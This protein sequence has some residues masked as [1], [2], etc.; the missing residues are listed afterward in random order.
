MNPEKFREKLLADGYLDIE[1]KS[2]EA[3][4]FVDKHSHAFDVRALVLEGEAT[5]D[6][7]GVPRT[8]RTGDVLEVAR[9]REHTEKYGAQGYTVMVGRRHP[10]G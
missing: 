10:A 7:D 8:Y 3:G 6:C 9:D 5:I 1:T 4:V 2:L